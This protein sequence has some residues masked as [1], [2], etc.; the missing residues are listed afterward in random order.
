MR[1]DTSDSAGISGISA[2]PTQSGEAPGA[3]GD[4]NLAR[5]VQAWATLPE[6]IL[7]AVLALIDATLPDA[8]ETPPKA[9]E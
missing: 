8:P 5:V 3:A 4:R 7:R 6:P 2:I 1:C 9:A